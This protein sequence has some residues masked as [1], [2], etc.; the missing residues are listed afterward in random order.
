MAI[1][2]KYQ[3]LSPIT[4]AVVSGSINSALAEMSI[5]MRRTAM[6]PVLAIGNDFSNMIC[7][8]EARTIAQGNDQPVHLGALIFATKAVST[9]I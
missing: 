5:T 6:S 1:Q 2:N 3:S 8:G 9:A 4:L 7:D